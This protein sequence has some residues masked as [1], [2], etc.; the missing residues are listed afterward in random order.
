M[1]EHSPCT[2]ISEPVHKSPSSDL[3]RLLVVAFAAILL[4]GHALSA[5]TLT[6]LYTF[7]GGSDG[8]KPQGALYLDST[9]ALFGET[10][11]GG[12]S[13]NGVAFKLTPPAGGGSWTES[14]LYSFS[15]PDGADPAGG[16]MA[17]SNTLV[18][19][20][21]SGGAFNQGTVFQLTPSG[22]GW[23]ETVLHSFAGSD[24][25]NPSVRLVADANGALYGITPVGGASNK[26]V[27][28]QLAPPNSPGGPWT[29]TV[30]HNFTG[31]SDGFGP[32]GVLL[33]D[34]SGA[35][36]G[37]TTQNNPAPG[38]AFR[39]TPPKPPATNW[40]F[41]VLHNDLATF[42]N[43]DFID[44]T[45]A[46]YGTTL[47]PNAFFKLSQSGSEK[48]LLKGIDYSMPGLAAGPG[49]TYYGGNFGG[50][51]FK[52]TPPSGKGGQWMLGDLLPSS[53]YN[54]GMPTLDSSGTIYGY[55]VNVCQAPLYGAVY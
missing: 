29:E 52:L 53:C 34:K 12:T 44:S 30:L 15:G 26:G 35:L 42:I 25:A 3:I 27:V 45:G 16:L 1:K 24:G 37:T 39:L 41:K 40:T 51:V 11:Q 22:G 36:Y 14:V 38:R 4:T 18:G 19:I 17:L 5:Q 50:R 23:T 32:F 28:F 10:A 6:L 47:G 55:D 43:V 33:I 31:G 54:Q 13:G 20:T 21:T 9:G 7:S 8:S 2:A 48:I 46:L 49:G